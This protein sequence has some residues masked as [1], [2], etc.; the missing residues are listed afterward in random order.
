[1]QP[2]FEYDWLMPR[3]FIAACRF[4]EL[5]IAV[6]DCPESSLFACWLIGVQYLPKL[7]LNDEVV[8]CQYCTSNDL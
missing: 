3:A 2:Y 8:M 1:M 6:R 5:I 7:E 4:E